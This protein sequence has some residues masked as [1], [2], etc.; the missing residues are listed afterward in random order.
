MTLR[1]NQSNK[2]MWSLI[3]QLAEKQ[4]KEY[5]DVYKELIHKYGNFIW[6]LVP[7][8]EVNEF[9]LQWTAHGSGWYAERVKPKSNGIACKVF[10]GT[11]MYQV[12][13]M[14]KFIEAIQNECKQYGIETM[15]P[16]ELAE[17]IEVHTN[18]KR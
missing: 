4:G 1:S 3:D 18:E 14:Q 2:Y 15:T 16:A 9:L 17:L 10:K 11:S 8:A 12:D 7:E 6:V 5:M 13:E